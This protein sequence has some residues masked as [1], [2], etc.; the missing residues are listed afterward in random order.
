MALGSLTKRFKARTRR[1]LD[2]PGSVELHPYERLLEPAAALE[3][4]LAAASDDEIRRRADALRAAVPW[5]DAERAELVALGREAASRVLGE[6]PFDVQVVGALALLDGHVVELATG[7]GKTLVGALA[8]AGYALQGRRVHVMTVNDYLASRDAAWMAPLH[9][10]LGVDAA[11]VTAASTAD[12]RR[13]AY[14][15]D[16]L[17]GSVAELGF[18]VLRDHLVRDASQSVTQAPDVLVVDEADSVLVDEAR[19][20]LV[21]AGAAEHQHEGSELAEVVRNL[22]PVVDY[23]VYDDGRNVALTDAGAH[24]IEAALGDIDLYAPEHADLHAAVNVALHAQTLVHRDVDYLVEDGKVGLVSASRGRV[25][26]LQ[27]WPDG[28]QAAVEAKEGLVASETGEVL[29]TTTVQ[30]LLR[31]YPTICGMTGTALAVA[32]QLTELYGMGVAAI[33]PNVPCVRV[34]EPDRL[35]RTGEARD[36]AVVA[37][38][39]EQHA[40]GRPVLVG[41]LDV[42]ESERLAESL[43]EAG[44]PCTV[45]NARNDADE[46]AVI[47][48][49]G[50]H[51][52]VTVSTQMAGRGVDIRLGGADEADRDRV[53]ALGGLLVLATGHYPTSRLDDQLRGR[54]GRQ[55]DPGT[56]M[57][58]ASLDDQV[59]VRYV[60]DADLTAY[61]ADEDGEVTDEGAHRLVAHAQRVAEGVQ[62]EILR[63]TWRYERL[64]EHQRAAVLA[65]RDAVLHEDAASDLLVERSA[66]AWDAAEAALGEEGVAE[67]ARQ[68]LLHELDRAWVDHVAYLADLREGIHLRALGR[69][70]PLDEYHR[71][72]IPSFETFLDDV[73][74]LAVEAF[75]AAVAALVPDEDGAAEDGTGSGGVDRAAPAPVPTADDLVPRPTATWTYVVQENPFG[76]EFERAL[77]AIRG[78]MG[79]NRDR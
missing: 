54:A 1:L 65:R 51:G 63:N 47:A 20:P 68:V 12:E 10:A 77:S 43:A 79:S 36:A 27:R 13:T 31:R 18:D 76:T 46:A 32:D 42:A 40:A 66:D 6:R 52:A 2:R 19:V 75:D 17:Y 56:S 15:A 35:F 74:G 60:P 25:N 70:S 69:L 41:T 49:A 38:I 72:A 5:G 37:E 55:G 21:L 71:E 24:A 3:D 7:E 8:S 9:A 64:A 22:E 16:V 26:K 59:V 11:A 57:I 50:A 28:L 73:D 45:L 62:L 53:A 67:L 39:V 23:E 58:F 30:A 44:V 48:D 78:R 33:E 61:A 14:E 29:D 34:D 4:E